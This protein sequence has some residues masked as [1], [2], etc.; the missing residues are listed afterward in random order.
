MI[1]FKTGVIQVTATTTA[2]TLKDLINTAKGSVVDY[3]KM[4]DIN[5]IEI[6]PEGAVR[7]TVDGADPTS[8][9]GL[10]GATDSYYVFDGVTLD[11]FKLYGSNIK[12]NIQIGRTENTSN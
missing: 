8:S 12:V 3:S 9:T 5:H 1:P 11:Q 4:P 6:N 7:F 2:S 10:K